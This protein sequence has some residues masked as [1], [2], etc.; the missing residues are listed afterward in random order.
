MSKFYINHTNALSFT[1]FNWPTEI[2]LL[3]Q[4]FF[5]SSTQPFNKHPANGVFI[6]HKFSEKFC[7]THIDLIDSWQK[8]KKNIWHSLTTMTDPVRNNFTNERVTV[9]SDD[10]GHKRSI[11][12]S[13]FLPFYLNH[14]NAVDASVSWTQPPATFS[15]FQQSNFVLVSH[16]IFGGKSNLLYP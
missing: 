12:T 3:C 15:R 11:K 16:F 8:I 1:V 2:S 6:C 9:N 4:K 10:H 13:L 7:C 5:L 14:F